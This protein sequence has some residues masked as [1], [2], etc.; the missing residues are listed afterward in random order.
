MN[1]WIFPVPYPIAG[2][3]VLDLRSIQSEDNWVWA[4]LVYMLGGTI[5]F[6]M[7][8]VIVVTFMRPLGTFGGKS[9]Q[10]AGPLGTSQEFCLS[11]PGFNG[12]IHV[13]ALL[14]PELSLI[15]RLF[16]ASWWPLLSE[17][18]WTTSKQTVSIKN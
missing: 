1:E 4:G 15:P 9:G 2:R 6:Q 7:V 11:S 13:V 14:A 12:S 3:L 10:V 16:W 18:C 17:T 8:N 5:L